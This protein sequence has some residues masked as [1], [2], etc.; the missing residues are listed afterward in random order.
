MTPAARERL[1]AHC[2][3]LEARAVSEVAD[4]DLARVDAVVLRS[5]PTLGSDELR[6]L[7]ALR[8]VVRPGSGV[9]NIDVRT[10]EARG[11]ELARNADLGGLGVGELCL[12]A[13]MLLARRVPLAHNGAAGEVHVPKG[14]L[15]GDDL[16]ALRA[17]VWGAGPVGRACAARLGPLVAGVAFAAHPSLRDDDE[18]VSPAA[19]LAEADVHVL[20]LPLREDTRA[21]VSADW[22][23][24]VRPRR[25][26]VLN[27]AR[28]GVL[29]L[30]AVADAVERDGLRGLFLEP[31][32]PEHLSGLTGLLAAHPPRNVLVSQHAGGQ[33][34]DLRGKLDAWAAE[35]LLDRLAG[36][37]GPVHGAP[38]R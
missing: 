11:I 37:A 22:L 10:L 25:P 33:R 13:L 28:M 35:T 12:A 36:I 7:P 24:A 20:A 31:V 9:D 1:E 30:V 29:D 23:A 6:Q 14:E 17:V 27:V 19:A 3:V 16:A 38:S 8:V 18:A 2:T 32:D 4:G 34:A 26:Y 21:L 5:G 15:L